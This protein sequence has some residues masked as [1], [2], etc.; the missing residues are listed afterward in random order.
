[1]EPQNL[2]RRYFLQLFLAGTTGL[3]NL[4]VLKPALARKAAPIVNGPHAIA[5]QEWPPAVVADHIGI[6]DRGL[7][8]LTDDFG[9]LAVVDLRKPQA[10]PVKIICE[11]SN[12][13][14]KVLDFKFLGNRGYAA[15]VKGSDPA[16][17]GLT[18]LTIDFM[19]VANP[20]VASQIALD[21]F[22]EI[23]CLAVSPDAICVA[24]VSPSGE[25]LVNIYSGSGKR[26]RSAEPALI[27]SFTTEAQVVQMDLQDKSLLILEQGQLDFV[28]LTDMRNPVMH[29]SLKLAGDFKTVSRV[30]DTAIVAGAGDD[31]AVVVKSVALGAT[32]H[33]VSTMT[34]D[35]IT[36][37]LDS[38]A[39]PGRFVVLGETARGRAFITLTL[40]KTRNLTRE[41]VTEMANERTQ[42]FGTKSRILLSNRTAYVASGWSGVSLFS[43]AR[44]GWSP[45]YKYSIP[46]LPASSV[47]TWGD[48]VVLAGSDLKLYDIAQI[49]HPNLVSSAETANAVKTVV[50]AGSFV[51][52]LAKDSL[53]LRKMDKLADTIA[54]CKISG[55]QMCFDSVV[56][57]AYVLKEQGKKTILTPVKVYSNS[58][59]AEKAQELLGGFSRATARGGLI[60]VAGLNDVT[61]YSM[62]ETAEL[63][64]GRHFENLA[65][66]DLSMTDDYI[67]ASAVDQ[68][69]K[70]FLLVLSKDKKDL[71]VIGSI[72][73]PQDA[74]AL[75]VSK[76]KVVVVGKNN[77]GKDIA[78]ILDV[79]MAATPKIIA[80]IPAVEAA[81]AVAIKDQVAIVGGRGIA[82]LSLT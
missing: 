39:Q 67:I 14:K 52:C 3:S 13:G 23:A 43:Y 46:R 7:C 42:G 76:S 79:T 1:M 19:P 5:R 65:I 11:M 36:T 44:D 15:V 9:R 18:L 77:E 59:V 41:Q 16:E 55:Q 17:P 51:L 22:S 25:N 32:P 71:R 20:T 2:S 8:C 21:K 28:G 69:S 60:A 29:K 64:G 62:S 63:V 40:D 48:L 70:G 57:R 4:A 35:P 10:G 53:T 47:A 56:Q 38:S 82:I 50:G 30:K 6:V 27:S 54:N 80:S 74:V 45:Y 12:L 75:A 58:L 73:L 33:V 24:G 34:L 37:V 81:S 31:G 26:G 68:K 66:R 49:S 72:D 78:T 61:L